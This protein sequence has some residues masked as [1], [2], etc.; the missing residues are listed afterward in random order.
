MLR[1]QDE[2]DAVRYLVERLRQYEATWHNAKACFFTETGQLS[3]YDLQ[4]A[5][6]S[7]SA[8]VARF[9]ISG[10]P[11]RVVLLPTCKALN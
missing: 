8:V 9:E 10:H 2:L 3:Q 4:C 7:A 6:T 1:Y 11:E 5:P